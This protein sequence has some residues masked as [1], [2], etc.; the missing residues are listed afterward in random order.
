VSTLGVND[1]CCVSKDGMET[2]ASAWDI[3]ECGA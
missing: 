1:R 3:G 2:G